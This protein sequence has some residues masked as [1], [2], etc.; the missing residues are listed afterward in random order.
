MRLSLLQ[1]FILKKCYGAKKIKFDCDYFLD[2]YKNSGKAQPKIQ[3]KIVRR[4]LENLID[5]GLMV[6]YGLRTP[7]KWFVKKVKLTGQGRKQAKKV[8]GEQLKLNLK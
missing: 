4:S 5:K 1:K 3:K 7:K 2:F 8:I 6:G